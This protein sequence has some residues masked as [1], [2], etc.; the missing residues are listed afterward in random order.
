MASISMTASLLPRLPST[1]ARRGLIVAN[2]S[3]ADNGEKV[4]WELK[5][6]SSNGRRELIFA[7]T[8]AAACSV[9]NIAMGEEPKAGTSEAKKKYA[10]VCVTMLTA[11][12]CRK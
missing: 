12:I 3:R 2:A 8:A 4:T 9:A 10:P 11:K 6:E 5:Q 7:A 1:I